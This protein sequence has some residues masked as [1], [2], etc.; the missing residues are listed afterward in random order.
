VISIRLVFYLCLAGLTNESHDKPSN[1]KM[2]V[3]AA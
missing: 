3:C 1:L 2:F